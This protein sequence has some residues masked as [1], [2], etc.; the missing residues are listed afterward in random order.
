MTARGALKRT[1]ILEAIA[2]LTARNGFAPSIQEIATE[3]GIGK[4][5][6]YQ[7]LVILRKQGSVAS[8]SRP[9]AGWKLDGV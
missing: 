6:C 1:R 7:H 3:I 5:A 9:G 4:T 8:G 2:A